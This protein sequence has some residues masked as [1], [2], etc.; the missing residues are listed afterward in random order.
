[1]GGCSI[2]RNYMF[3]IS[4]NFW[5]IVSMISSGSLCYFIIKV[6][7][8]WSVYISSA[9][10]R[11]VVFINLEFYHWLLS[12]FNP[13]CFLTSATGGQLVGKEEFDIY[14]I[15]DSMAGMCIREV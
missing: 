11:F 5:W 8:V 9:S 12:A 13:I 2:I 1:M 3:D 7:A 14:G 4:G 6:V 15:F 10:C